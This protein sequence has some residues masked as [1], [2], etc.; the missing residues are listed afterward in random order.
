MIVNKERLQVPLQVIYDA[1]KEGEEN[2]TTSKTLCAAFHLSERELRQNIESLRRSG[3]VI[4]SSTKGYYL[5]G[6]IDELRR[7]V[8]QER[9]RALSVLRI[10]K[11]AVDKLK[12]DESSNGFGGYS[13]GE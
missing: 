2:A 4:L 7:F 12:E 8:K 3:L 1:L 13:I 11:P 10:L 5:A 9:S 6:T